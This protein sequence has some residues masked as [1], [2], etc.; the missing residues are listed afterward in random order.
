[1]SKKESINSLDITDEGLFAAGVTTGVIM[2]IQNLTSAFFIQL[3][4]VA[5]LK[6]TSIL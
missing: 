3:L 4:P 6:K 1:M 5:Q 2:N